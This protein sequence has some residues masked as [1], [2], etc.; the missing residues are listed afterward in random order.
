MVDLASTGTAGVQVK[1]K[2]LT[3]F[4]SSETRTS[5]EITLTIGCTTAT[6]E[7]NNGFSATQNTNVI[8][9]SAVAG[10][11]TYPMPT[12]AYAPCAITSNALTDILINT[13]PSVDAVV[14]QGAALCTQPCTIVD[15]ASTAT[16]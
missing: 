16:E 3:T 11:Y 12:I 1:F 15:L 6:I 8:L 10:R 13:T 4:P 2:F 14:F 9:D 5:S 7:V